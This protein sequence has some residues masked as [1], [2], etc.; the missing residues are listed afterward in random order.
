VYV[1]SPAGSSTPPSDTW[2][3]YVEGQRVLVTQ[4]HVDHRQHGTLAVED[5][6]QE[7]WQ[8]DIVDVVGI[9]LGDVLGTQF[10]RPQRSRRVAGVVG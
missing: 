5:A 7:T 10:G 4:R 6:V 8:D 9:E 1:L 2:T 3:T